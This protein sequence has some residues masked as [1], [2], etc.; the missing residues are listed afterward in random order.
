M[1]QRT[2]LS[3]D[4]REKDTI[5]TME[6]ASD[7]KMGHREHTPA[8]CQRACPQWGWRGLAE[9]S[10]PLLVFRRNCSIPR[11]TIN[12]FNSLRL[13]T[14]RSTGRFGTLFKSIQEEDDNEEGEEGYTEEDDDL[15]MK[16]ALP[17]PFMAP[18]PRPLPVMTSTQVMTAPHLQPGTTFVTHN[19]PP[20]YP[21]SRVFTL[22][23]APSRQSPSTQQTLHRQPPSSSA[24]RLHP[25]SASDG[26]LEDIPFSPDG[27]EGTICR[28]EG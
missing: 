21:E 27:E 17:Q 7:V 3:K 5:F 19:W 15:E 20:Q 1:P 14:T 2:P 11:H 8:Q 4:T 10:M 18:K 6:T 9:M 26:H 13:P 25:V 16:D 24:T 28:D 23:P 12:V 22:P